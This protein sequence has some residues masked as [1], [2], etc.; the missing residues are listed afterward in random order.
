MNLLF[1]PP[2]PSMHRAMVIV[3]PTTVNFLDA[4]SV[5]LERA[6]FFVMDRV[7]LTISSDDDLLLLADSTDPT[8]ADELKAIMTGG[9]S[10]VFLLEGLNLIPELELLL[11]SPDPMHAKVYF[12]TS[13]RAEMGA[14][15]ANNCVHAVHTTA[16]AVARMHTWFP[17]FFALAPESTLAIIKPVTATRHGDDIMQIIRTHGFRIDRTSRR[18]LSREDAME[19]YAEHAGKSFYESLMAYMTSD[20]VIVLILTRVKA[21]YAWRKCMGPTNSTIAKTQFPT[22]IRGR[23]GIDGT[24]NAT[25]GSDSVASARREIQLMFH[26]AVVAPGSVPTKALADTPS[27][28]TQKTLHDALARGITQLCQLN[29]RLDAALDACEW[30]GRFLVRDATNQAPVVSVGVSASVGRSKPRK[31]APVDLAVPSLAALHIVGFFGAPRNRSWLAAQLAKDFGYH[32]M[33]LD[34]VLEKK[35]PHEDSMAV[36]VKAFKRCVWKR[37]IV[38]HCPPDLTFYLAFQKHVAAFAWIT[39]VADDVGDATPRTSHGTHASPHELPFPTHSPDEHEFY[40][41][42]HK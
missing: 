28:Y 39:V 14:T 37:V 21:I 17:S 8:Y 7:T 22:S 18:H 13:I 19:F 32:Y 3:K 20:D 27:K 29:P 15:R 6:G 9:A 35:E 2:L 5:R 34:T 16:A 36:I 12:P 10:E 1:P 38:D 41:F 23:F 33:N 31:A 11:G 4:I 25:H 40:D 42:F 24:K 26:V 30:L